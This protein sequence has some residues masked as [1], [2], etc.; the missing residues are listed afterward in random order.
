MSIRTVLLQLQ[1]KGIRVEVKRPDDPT[2]ERITGTAEPSELVNGSEVAVAALTDII[3]NSSAGI[4]NAGGVISD[5]VKIS[6]AEG[7]S[8]ASLIE[9][10]VCR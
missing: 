5:F 9:M 6:E 4:T 7:E 1:P 2:W 10:D 3:T 8:P